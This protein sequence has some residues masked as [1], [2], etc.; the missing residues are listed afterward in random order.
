MQHAKAG[1][2]EWVFISLSEVG[3]LLPTCTIPLLVWHCCSEIPFSGITQDLS[4]YG[5][6]QHVR[7]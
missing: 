7:L 6:S 5:M 4:H 2:I 1:G 3:A